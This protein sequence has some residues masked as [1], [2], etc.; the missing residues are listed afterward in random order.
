MTRLQRLA[1][2][3]GYD[4]SPR[5][6]AK[7]LEAQLIAVLERFEIACVLDVGANCGQY[8]RLL[9]AWG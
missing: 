3:F 5:K 2:R 9:R 4:L 1:R 8:G 7:P 6:K